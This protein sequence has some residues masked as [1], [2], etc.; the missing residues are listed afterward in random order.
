MKFAIY[1]FIT[2]FFLTVSCQKEEIIMHNQLENTDSN[3][4][5]DCDK[6][7][8]ETDDMTTLGTSSDGDFSG[9]NG[10]TPK[11]KRKRPTDSDDED[12]FITDPNNDEDESRKKH[13]KQNN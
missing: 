5:C 3:E 4:P 10:D 12:D 11:N 13:R 7:K 8:V 2:I 1:I 9:N 6:Q